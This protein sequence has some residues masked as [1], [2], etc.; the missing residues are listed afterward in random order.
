METGIDYAQL[1][2]A[3]GDAIVISDASGAITLWNPAAERMFGFT[4]AEALGKSLDLIIP[5]R[6]RGRHW[7]G[8]QKTM[9]SGQTR[10]GNDVL[11]VPA[12]DSQGRSLSIAFTVA[13]LYSP[14][15]ELTGI[16]AVIRDE[17][18]RFQEE[19][20]LRKRVTE[21]EAQANA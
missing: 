7:D 9:A 17:T 6:L 8:Y 14:A 10:Y 13:L 3:I 12:I 11:R 20:A 19:R 15:H 18:S 21:L 4:E 5:E 2:S 16:V 1:V